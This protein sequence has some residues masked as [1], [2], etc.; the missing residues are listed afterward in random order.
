MRKV[1]TLALLCFLFSSVYAQE[2]TFPEGLKKL[3]EKRVAKLHPDVT[4]LPGYGPDGQLWDQEKVSDYKTYREYKAEFYVDK[5]GKIV[6]IKFRT[7]SDQERAFAF[8]E[9]EDM[10]MKALLGTPALDFETTDMEGNTIKLSELKG[11]VVAINFWYIGCRPCVQEIPE[12]NEIVED[13]QG[14]PVKFVAVALDDK[15]DLDRFLADRPFDYDLVASGRPVARI[16]EIGGYP[17]HLI[18]DQEGNIVYF[19]SGYGTMTSTL[20]R[21]NLDDLLAEK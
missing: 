17:T 16:Y 15:K 1:L 4:K 2:Q 12:L 9:A 10:R 18:I 20:I 13:Y 8:F 21:K 3:S 7:L 6:A 19:K 5:S 11:S 14:K